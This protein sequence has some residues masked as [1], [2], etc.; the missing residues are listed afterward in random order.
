MPPNVWRS[1]TRY[2]TPSLVAAGVGVF[3]VSV[4][5]FS[6][7]PL[8]PAI[9][10]TLSLSATE[11]GLLTM[12]FGVGRLAADLP[13]GVLAG[14][15]SAATAFALACGLVTTGCGLLATAGQGAQAYVAAFVLGTGSALSN[16]AGMTTF[17]G[18]PSERRGRALAIFSACLLCGQS[19][20]PVLGG[21][22]VAGDSSWRVAQGVAG[23]L[24]VLGVLAFVVVNV[25][26]ASQRAVRREARQSATGG[27]TPI[28]FVQLLILYAVP[29]VVFF[30]LA[31]MPQTLVPIIGAE[32]LRLSAGV[33]GLAL[34]VGGVCRLV[35]TL[36][37]GYVSDRFGRK[38]A[39]IPGLATMAVGIALVAVPE[40]VVM[41]LAGIAL[42]SVGS[43]GV[44][45][46]ATILADRSRYGAVGRRL[47]S[48]RF[49]G[50]IGMIIGP[51]LGGWLY[52]V[53]G[54]AVAVL[55]VAALPA[56]VAVAAA[57]G[58]QQVRTRQAES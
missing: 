44:S 1:W 57:A 2:A 7:I 6:R 50:D 8:L 45:V 15:V 40:S 53:H 13:A 11:L 48:F 3:L 49:F 27:G 18:V 43:F 41:W 12:A 56:A 34:G 4:M 24:G 22:L 37:G 25:R 9:G 52:S 32:S 23:A 54:Q 26:S 42:M 28:P 14:K 29:F 17:S 47:G 5:A 19:F 58:L 31:A 33:V 39:L 35:G 46:A 21:A 20:G 36:I 10:T 55:V 30:M 38:M 51:V 16:T